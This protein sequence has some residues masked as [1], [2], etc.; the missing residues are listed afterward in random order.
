MDSE[1]KFQ[2]DSITNWRAVEPS[3]YCSGIAV[4]GPAAEQHWLGMGARGINQLDELNP[5]N[6]AKRIVLFS[7]A[8]DS[9]NG[10]DGQHLLFNRIRSALYNLCD[11]HLRPYCAATQRPYPLRELVDSAVPLDPERQQLHKVSLA[12]VDAGALCAS[13][14]DGSVTSDAPIRFHVQEMMA[15]VLECKPALVIVCSDSCSHLETIYGSHASAVQ[16]SVLPLI[17]FSSRMSFSQASSDDRRAHGLRMLHDYRA[18]LVNGRAMLQL[19]IQRERNTQSDYELALK[20]GVWIIEYL[21]L[22]GCWRNA[23]NG[24]EV[25]AIEHVHDHLD[26]VSSLGWSKSEHG[27]QM[28]FSLDVLSDQWNIGISN[29]SP[30]GCSLQEL[31]SVL[32]Y[33]GRTGLCRVL[34]IMGATNSDSGAGRAAEIIATLIYKLVVL[35]E[36]YSEC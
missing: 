27:L 16:A 22:M 13:L 24:R 25:S 17:M 35:R 9:K 33:L 10:S 2:Q 34:H 30:F 1:K 14:P 19:G 31:G 4:A 6:L 3:S 8:T 26:K 15:R 7:Y 5:E 20:H 11:S 18:Q 28:A 36:E 21:Y 32:T 23:L 29:A 12:V